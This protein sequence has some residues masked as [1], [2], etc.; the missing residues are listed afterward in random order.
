M[1]QSDTPE[2]P[3]GQQTDGSSFTIK[4]VPHVIILPDGTKPLPLGSGTITSIL[5]IGGMSNVYEIWNP[6]LEVKRAVKLLHPNYS[7]DSRQRF[8]TE[9]KISAKL[10]HPNIV[11]IHAV[12]VWNGLPFIEMEKVDGCTL[13]KLITDRGGLPLEVCTSIGILIGRAL[14][15]AHNHEYALYGQSYH[16]IIHRDLKPNNIMVANSG[17]VKLMDFGVARP[18]DASIH[19]TDNSSVLGTMQY[20]S[21]EL[22]EGKSADIRTDIYSLCAVLYEAVTGTKAFPE[23]NI[24]TLMMR[25]IKNEYK[26]L[27]SYAIRIPPRFKRIIQKCMNRDREKRPATVADLL[28]E[29]GRIHKSLT[30]LSPEAVMTNFMS[31]T[32]GS[33]TVV[34][35][36]RR[37]PMR[38]IGA[39]CAVAMLCAIAVLMVR[40]ITKQPARPAATTTP[41]TMPKPTAPEAGQPE[42][43]PSVKKV[44]DAM[45]G[46]SRRQS[47]PLSAPQRE[48][49]LK[50]GPAPDLFIA[51]LKQ[52]YGT[53]D[54]ADIFVREVKTGHY[55]EA[56][57][58][59]NML[60]LGQKESKAVVLF[61]LRTLEA[62]GGQN[63][64]AQVVAMQSIDDGEFYLARARQYY[65][66]GNTA[67]CLAFLDLS[68]KTRCEFLSPSTLRQE[69]LYYRALCYSREF[70]SHP[71]KM[72]MQTALDS[73]FEVKLQFRAT[74][75]HN[76][77]RKAVLEMQRIG[78][79]GKDIKG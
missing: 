59:F 10:D 36:R 60:S 11:E 56:L 3:Q 7:L 12:G 77:F 57:K 21:P 38:Q 54:L 62:T 14:R 39:V 32:A 33:K 27:D 6:Q 1:D 74:P 65:R 68:G 46:K 28:T 76:H 61:R 31:V 42:A 37:L 67:K 20:L 78:D 71:S 79:K 35:L 22:L 19:T 49:K 64:V 51:E 66:E 5:G 75:E 15:Y 50:K 44:S 47:G 69:T 26:P 72:T 4:K 45:L 25:K 41:T 43:S 8:E 24:S 63:A 58:V 9:I 16:G 18:I 73:W 53:D 34:S 70:D 55:P 23:S 17:V 40:F 30:P 2:T 48:V 29:L 52:M 13:E